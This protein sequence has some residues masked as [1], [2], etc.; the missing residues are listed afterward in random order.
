MKKNL[1]RIPLST[2][3]KYAL[4][5]PWHVVILAGAIVFGVGNWSLW[6][7]LFIF[8]TAEFVL[9]AIVFNLKVFQRYVQEKIDSQV[10]EE[11]NE[12]RKVILNQ[13]RPSEREKFNSLQGMVARL[14]GKLSA[15]PSI[16]SSIIEECNSLLQD[17]LRVAIQMS[18]IVDGPSTDLNSLE[19][20][21]H[22]LKRIRFPNALTQQRIE[23]LTHHIEWRRQA[24]GIQSDAFQYLE[25]IE[26]S[27]K[28]LIDRTFLSL[29]STLQLKARVSSDESNIQMDQSAI[30]EMAEF[31]HIEDID[32]SAM[33]VK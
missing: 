31:L 3:V 5:H 15:Y 13:M 14:A 11:T 21:L 17:Y 20:R 32:L 12:A 33:F 27:I 28:F 7:L 22:D 4:M 23:R 1:S 18:L 24:T 8:F 16:S 10:E 2:K 29:S 19:S 9:L 25:S 30:E 26:D 6:L